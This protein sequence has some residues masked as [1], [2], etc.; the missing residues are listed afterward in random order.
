MTSGFVR[1]IKKH[2]FLV[3]LVLTF[4]ISW[5]PWLINGQEM[6]VFGPTIAGLILIIITKGK[7]GGISSNRLFV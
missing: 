1:F 4:L 6:L 5:G 7:D 3:F 2:A